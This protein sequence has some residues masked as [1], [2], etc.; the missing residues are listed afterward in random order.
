MV[1]RVQSRKIVTFLEKITHQL[2]QVSRKI[3]W[4]VQDQN[5][6]QVKGLIEIISRKQETRYKKR[7]VL[8]SLVSVAPGAICPAKPSPEAA[9]EKHSNHMSQVPRFPPLQTNERPNGNIHHLVHIALGIFKN[10]IQVSKS[11]KVGCLQHDD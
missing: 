11:Y 7:A 8:S 6:S 10:H 2:R 3:S 9:F 1:S 4:L 5:Y